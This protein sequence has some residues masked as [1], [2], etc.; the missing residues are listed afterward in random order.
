VI[1]DFGT[2]QA[3][4]AD[5][6]I[7]RNRQAVSFSTR[8]ADYI[9]QRRSRN[10]GAQLDAT[11]CEQQLIPLFGLTEPSVASRLTSIAIAITVLTSSST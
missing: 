5:G 6:T 1:D 8:R 9:A 10:S 11:H 7:G 2:K 4:I 3:R